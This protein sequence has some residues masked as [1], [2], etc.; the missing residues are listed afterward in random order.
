[1]ERQVSNINAVYK[2]C[3]ARIADTAFVECHGTGT[4]QGDRLEL[5]A[6]SKSL[7]RDRSSLYPIIVGSVKTNIGHLEGSAG[8]AGFIKAVLTVEKGFIPKHSNFTNPNPNIDFE[9]LKVKVSHIHTISM[10]SFGQLNR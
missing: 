8:V 3:G 2:N 1:M 5:H 10:S 4:Q 7:C 9:A 6:V